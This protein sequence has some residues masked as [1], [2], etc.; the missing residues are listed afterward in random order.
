MLID[1]ENQKD[2]SACTSDLKH[3]RSSSKWND[4]IS[5]VG[6]AMTESAQVGELIIGFACGSKLP[7]VCLYLSKFHILKTLYWRR[8]P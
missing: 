1:G 2:P 8:V 6:S 5:Q 7:T 4:D 3:R